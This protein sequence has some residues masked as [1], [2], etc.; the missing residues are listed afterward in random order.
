MGIR[1]KEQPLGQV[2][3]ELID[4]YKL[5][6][7]LDEVELHRY[8]Q[9]LMGPQINAGTEALYL[10]GEK[11]LVRLSNPMLR[12]ELQLSKIKILEKLNEQ[13]GKDR[14]KDLIFI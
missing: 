10:Q 5:R 8:W 3:N 7:K 1:G 4:A 6:G 11:V 2:L 12:H 13:F 14:I 9:Q